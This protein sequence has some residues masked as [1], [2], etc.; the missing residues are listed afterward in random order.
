MYDMSLE[1]LNGS[2]LG[3]KDFWDKNYVSEITNYKSH[4]DVG[5]VWFDEDSQIRIIHWMI[6]D[7]IPEDKSIIDL[8]LY[9]DTPFL[10][11]VRMVNSLFDFRVWQW[12][13]AHRTVARELQKLDR[14]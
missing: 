14:Y 12:H 13:D 2:E 4:G 11:C 10:V 7:E 8:G 3:T 1:E 9:D 6:K 5:E